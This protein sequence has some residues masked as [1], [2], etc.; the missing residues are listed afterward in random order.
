MPDLVRATAVG[1]GLALL[2]AG[3]AGEGALPERAQ[4]DRGYVSGDGATVEVAVAERGDPV[5]VTGTDAEGVVVDLADFRGE[6]VVL[7]VWYATC[8][9]CRAEAP[10]LA[11]ISSETASDGVQFVG[12]NT[13]DDA[14]TA[15]AFQRTFAIGYPSI[16]DTS[17]EAVLALRG[18]VPPQAVPTT[19]VVD[20][21]GR[22]AA[23]IL[24]TADAGTLR[25]L[26]E[27]AVAEPA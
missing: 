15:Q 11:A 5:E 20:R 9:P 6:V 4:D 16:I 7:N 2:L 13:R 12:V 22:I 10:D 18:Q 8:P 21:Q 14:A 3:C 23:R 1:L 26:I 25:T 19:L 24:G 17:G 27:D